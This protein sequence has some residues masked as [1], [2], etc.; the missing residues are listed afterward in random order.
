M[1]M[2]AFLPLQYGEA[3]SSKDPIKATYLLVLAVVVLT[4]AVV[5]LATRHRLQGLGAVMG[6]ATVGSVVFHGAPDHEGPQR[7]PPCAVETTRSVGG[8]D[9]RSCC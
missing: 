3:T 1:V 5:V 8:D 4:E 6:S 9:D 7:S 2:C